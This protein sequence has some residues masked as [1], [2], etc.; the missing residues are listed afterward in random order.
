[1]R[2]AIPQYAKKYF[3]DIDLNAFDSKK[4]S[5]FTIER[6]LEYG[7]EKAVLWLFKHYNI[8]NIKNVTHQSKSLTN[9]S[10]NFWLTLL[11]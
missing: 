8:E 3:W 2:N 9:K 4:F 10:R 11:Q 5:F 1:M 7:D 6:I